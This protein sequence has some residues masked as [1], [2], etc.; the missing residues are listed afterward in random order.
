M[1]IA[2]MLLLGLSLVTAVFAAPSTGSKAVVEWVAHRGESHDAPENTLAAYTL[3]WERGVPAAELDVHLTKDGQLILIHD[4][5]TKRTAGVDLIVKN[6]TVE[7]LQKLD[8]GSWKNPKYAGEK[9]PLLED[10]LKAMPDGRK[11]YVEVK[12]GAEAVP[13]LVRVLKKVGKKPEQTPVIS[14]KL[15]TCIATK[16]AMP[17]LKVYYLASQKQNKDTGKWSPANQELIA[18]AKQHGFDGLDLS[19]KGPIDADFVKAAKA[20]GLEFLVWT[21]DDP[22]EA[23]R[24]IDAGVGAITSNRPAWLAEQV[25]Q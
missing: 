5:T 7:E 20:Q 24:M 25:K 13:E 16:K 18:L 3:A 21:I 14:F 23:K 17:E 22:A 11:M 10:V 12:V 8:V 6:S 9:M 19:Y 2:L 4:A 15:D 1:K